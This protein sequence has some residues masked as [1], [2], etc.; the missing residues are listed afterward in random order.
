MSLP[1]FPDER[2]VALEIL[3]PD[4]AKEWPSIAATLEKRGFPK[5]D[6]LYGGRYW[7]AVLAWYLRDYGIASNQLKP[8]AVTVRDI[9]PDRKEAFDAKTPQPLD[10]RRRAGRD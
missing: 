9:T 8:A 7:P 3:G 2:R 5:I 1:L 6:P 4:R 10:R